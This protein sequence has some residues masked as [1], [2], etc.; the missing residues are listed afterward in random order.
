M[1]PAPDALTG[2][3]MLEIVQSG[4]SY[5][6]TAQ[7]IANLSPSS[8]TPNLQA[9]A[10]V[11][12]T[13]STIIE[14]TA[15][16]TKA[17]PNFKFT[18]GN[19]IW[20]S[21][22]NQVAIV[23]NSLNRVF[24]NSSGSSLFRNDTDSQTNFTISSAGNGQIMANQAAGVVACNNYVPMQSGGG[25]NHE[26]PSSTVGSP[27]R[28]LIFPSG[29]CTNIVNPLLDILDGS[30][31]WSASYDKITRGS[32]VY[33][34]TLNGGATR[35]RNLHIA[36][37]TNLPIGTA[38][39]VAGT[40]TVNNTLITA[41]SKVFTTG[42]GT[43]VNVAAVNEVKASRVASTSFVLQSLNVLDTQDVDWWIVEPY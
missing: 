10:S 35:L 16:T 9:V 5:R 2:A 4:V 38:T 1:N 11:G 3:E 34:E 15:S 28:F 26:I 32:T 31:L 14:S 29:T 23:T 6:T 43:G 20:L 30:S 19:G 8:P 21:A 39:L 27:G 17:N 40:V 41:N 37:G 12:N 33:R 22:T 7:E 25:L 24:I 36:T 42:K 18:G 13:T